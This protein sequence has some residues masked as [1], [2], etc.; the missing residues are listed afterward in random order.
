VCPVQL[1]LQL[2]P[3]RIRCNAAG[4]E[5]LRFVNHLTVRTLRA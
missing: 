2:S 5:V 4:T 3:S 1:D